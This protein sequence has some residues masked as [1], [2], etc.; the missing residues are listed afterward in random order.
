MSLL[1]FV[2]VLGGGGAV[3]L[4][5]CFLVCLFVVVVVVLGGL[6][7]F[8]RFLLLVHLKEQ[9]QYGWN[10]VYIT[11]LCLRLFVH[12]DLLYGHF[13]NGREKF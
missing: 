1:F 12:V 13:C 11:R 9:L 4:F 2:V 6:S 8:V 3:F 5:V 10:I 7:L